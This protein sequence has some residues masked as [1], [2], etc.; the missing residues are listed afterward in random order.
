MKFKAAYAAYAAVLA[1][2]AVLI[3]LIRDT[4]AVLIF[5]ACLFAAAAVLALKRG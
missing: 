4:Y 2:P 3:F 1:V 5:S